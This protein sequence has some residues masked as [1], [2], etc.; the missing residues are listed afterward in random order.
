MKIKNVWNIKQLPMKYVAELENGELA[1]FNIVPF[2]IVSVGELTPFKG[3]HPT[4]QSSTEMPEY[5]YRFYGL[6]R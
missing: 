4:R 5:L 3:P 6:E 1:M 2:R